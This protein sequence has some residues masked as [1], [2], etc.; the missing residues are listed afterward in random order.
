MRIATPQAVT[1]A[2]KSRDTTNLCTVVLW[3]QGTSQIVIIFG[4]GLNRFELI[5]HNGKI[6]IYEWQTQQLPRPE[7]APNQNHEKNGENHGCDQPWTYAK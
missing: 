6:T 4:S 1:I 5:C 7:K 3:Q 2:S